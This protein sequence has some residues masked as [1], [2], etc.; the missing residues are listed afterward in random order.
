MS[1]VDS[2]RRVESKYLTF[3]Q[4][5]NIKVVYNRKLRKPN[6]KQERILKLP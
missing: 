5:Q 2:I 6:G 3:T 4:R 1:G